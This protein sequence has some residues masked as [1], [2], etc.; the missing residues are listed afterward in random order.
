MMNILSQ[1]KPKAKPTQQSTSGMLM[2]NN[3]SLS[4]AGSATKAGIS[5]AIMK[6][7]QGASL[8]NINEEGSNNGDSHHD[9]TRKQMSSTT[10]M[11]M[12]G[13]SAGKKPSIL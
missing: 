1:G 13:K 12:T 10:L 2:L 6:K 4:L 11:T 7:S 5:Q 9:M 3:V 8:L